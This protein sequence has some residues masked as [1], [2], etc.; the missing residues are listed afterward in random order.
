MRPSRALLPVQSTRPPRPDTTPL[1]RWQV[2]GFS[3]R[4][5]AARRIRHSFAK[6][7]SGNQPSPFKKRVISK[8][9][10]ETQQNWKWPWPGEENLDLYVRR[11]SRACPFPASG[12][13]LVRAWL[14]WLR[15][16]TAIVNF[17]T[18]LTSSFILFRVGKKES[19]AFSGLSNNNRSN[20]PGRV[21][22]SVRVRACVCVCVYVWGERCV[23]AH[24]RALT[25][26]PLAD[27]MF[28]SG[29]G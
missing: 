29:G 3:H 28:E 22:Y 17:H 6:G 16:L 24:V 1:T 27:R 5:F 11:K 14:R 2:M 8:Q 21:C 15:W 9:S 4:Q 12:V 7:M 25:L 26:Q 13:R 19:I 10:H 18:F 23:C 20:P